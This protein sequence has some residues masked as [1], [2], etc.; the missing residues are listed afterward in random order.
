MPQGLSGLNA[1]TASNLILDAGAVYFNI[2]L[3]ALDFSGSGSFETS[4]ANAIAGATPVGATRGGAVFNA[5]RELRE[6][7]ADGQLGATKGLIRR[8]NIRPTLT[9]NLLEQSLENLQRQFPGAVVEDAGLFDKLVGGPITNETYIDN[10]ALIT[11]YG[12]EGRYIVVVVKNALVMASPDFTTEDKNEVSTSVEFVGTF[13]FDGEEP[14]AVYLPKP[15]TPPPPPPPE[16]SIK[17]DL[18]GWVSGVEQIS[19]S[20]FGPINFDA[21]AFLV[22]YRFNDEPSGYSFS[23]S[24]ADDPANPTGSYTEVLTGD[25]FTIEDLPLSVGDLPAAIT[26]DSG[27]FGEP[28]SDY[29]LNGGEARGSLAIVVPNVGFWKLQIFN[30]D[31][32]LVHERSN[33]LDI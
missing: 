3:E 11:T 8:T 32:Y 25:S 22:F 28:L 33:F 23:L 31:T 6:I 12:E 7:E 4:I 5:N 20:L 24:I 1:N 30:T 29:D 16:L 2:N 9:V 17:D 26:F 14:W 13:G 10:V 15:V 27:L 21:N 19:A 18:N